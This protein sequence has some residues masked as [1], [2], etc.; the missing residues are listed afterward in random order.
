MTKEE[1][2]KTREGFVSGLRH[3][4]V[5]SSIDKVSEKM[6]GTIS[7]TVNKSL[8]NTHPGAVVAAPLVDSAIKCAVIVGCA[9]M[10]EVA[11]PFVDQTANPKKIAAASVFLREYAGEKIGHDVVEMAV[12]LLPLIMSAFS[13]ISVE[14]LKKTIEDQTIS[15]EDSLQES[16]ESFK[17]DLFIPL[18]DEED[19]DL[20]ESETKEQ[21]E[22]A[23]VEKI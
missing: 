15:E 10:L 16:K 9:E 12:E 14:D 1:K 7:A 6:V 19:N 2:M 11:L 17:E 21:V 18:L 22:S 3:G 13:E 20:K 4:A 23:Q 8:Q 5:K